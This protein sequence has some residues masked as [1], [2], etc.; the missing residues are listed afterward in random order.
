MKVNELNNMHCK[1]KLR[2]RENN[3]DLQNR[4]KQELEE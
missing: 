3:K 1:N 4:L 2:L